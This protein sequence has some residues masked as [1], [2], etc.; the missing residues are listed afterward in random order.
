ML[1]RL[2]VAVGCVALLGACDQKN[3]PD[4]KIGSSVTE[5]N[6]AKDYPDE[7]EGAGKELSKSEQDLGEASKKFADYPDQIKEPTDYKRVGEV[8]D[9]ADSAGKS[10]KYVEAH[11]KNECVRRYFA[12][13]NEAFAK[14]VAGSVGSV[15]QQKGCPAGDVSGAA[16][17]AMKK[18]LE[19]DLQKSEREANY[20][21]LV[22]QRHKEQIGKD[23]VPKVEEQ[24]DEIA[25]ASYTA[26]IALPEKKNRLKKLISEADGIKKTMDK[27]IED[28]KAF[29]KEE[30]RTDAEKKASDARIKEMEDAKQGLDDLVKEAKDSEKELDKQVSDAQKGHADA[31]SNLKSELKKRAS[32]QKKK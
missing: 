13:D 4:P 28:E 20:A 27:F 19:D 2:L 26:N 15:A 17:Y 29:Q 18:T 5:A 9:A 24:A 3:S 1:R 30:G 21:H 14:K 25:E 6:Y 22:I 32:D 11:R 16:M 23:N 10:E 31:L 8:V 12:A 7:L